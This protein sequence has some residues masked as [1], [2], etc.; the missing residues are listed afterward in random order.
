MG[1]TS[2]NVCAPEQC[3]WCCLAGKSGGFKWFANT[4]RFL[5]EIQEICFYFQLLFHA[6]SYEGEW[7]RGVFYAFIEILCALSVERL[8]IMMAKVGDA[9][10]SF[11][12]AARCGEE[13]TR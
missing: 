7:I 6:C 8:S 11:R 4:F 1:G 12:F 9:L 10:S 3:R 2:T 5:A 13:S